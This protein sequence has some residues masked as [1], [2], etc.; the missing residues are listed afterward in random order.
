[1]KKLIASFIVFAI[2]LLALSLN[3]LIKSEFPDEINKQLSFNLTSAC[4]GEKCFK[5]RIADT[6]EKRAQ[7]LMFVKEMPE[8]E[9]MF[10]IF[11]KEEIHPFWMKNTLIPLDI[12]WLDENQNIV[13]IKKNVLPCKEDPCE[14]INPGKPARYV[15]EINAGLVDKLNLEE[16]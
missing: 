7:G 16:I 2:F 10:F 8:Y 15:L 12:I 11:E 14:V 6:Q 3:F 13:F 4:F 1:M 9:G 5:V